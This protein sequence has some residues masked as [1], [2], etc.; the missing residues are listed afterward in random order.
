ML[1][2][3]NTANATNY[4]VYRSINNSAFSLVA[5]V[6]TSS[7]SD[8]SF[9]INNNGDTIRYYVVANNSG[10]DS[11]NSATVSVDIPALP[12][13]PNNINIIDNNPS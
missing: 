3:T 8:N 4:K 12:G 9:D 6:L 13:R 10:G 11:S 1:N 5:T 2:W 7:Y